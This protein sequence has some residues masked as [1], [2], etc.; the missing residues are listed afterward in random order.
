MSEVITMTK[1]ELAEF[2]KGIVKN[3]LVEMGLKGSSL[4]SGRIYRQ[5]MIEILG[6]RSMFDRAVERG[7]LEIHKDGGNTSKVWAR[8]GDWELF[9][10][11]HTN[12]KL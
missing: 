4:R 6:S 3:T 2:G 8:R 9:I 12:K 7:F 1:E 11:L 5:E 10:K